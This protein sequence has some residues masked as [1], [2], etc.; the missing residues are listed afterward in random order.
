MAAVNKIDS[1]V[2]ALR[3]AE[4]ATF[5]ANP[6]AVNWYDLEPNSYGDFGGNSTL[7]ARNPI[8]AG[9]Q[10]KKGVITDKDASGALQQDVT[11]T[12]FERLLQG[13]F[14]AD[15]REKP[16][17]TSFGSAKIVIDDVTTLADTYTASGG[18]YT[19]GG[20]G[21]LA[22]DIV[23]GTGFTESANNGLHVVATVGA[24][25][26]T[27]DENLVDETPP[28]AARLTMVGHEF[29]AGDLSVVVSG[30][31]PT[32]VSAGGKDLT[33][34]GLIPGEFIYV[35]GDGATK[36]FFNAVN[37]GFARVK[38]VTA[39]VI[40]LDKTESTMVADDGTIDGAGGAGQ[41]IRIFCG[42]VLK[43]ETGSL[44][45]RRTYHLE[46]E[47]GAPDDEEPA[48]IQAEYLE[49]A[50]PNEITFNFSTADKLTADLTF[51]AGDSA[52]VAGDVALRSAAGTVVTVTESDAFNTSS[53]VVRVNMHVISST[54]AAPTPLLGFFEEFTIAISNGVTPNKA[55]G[56]I[57]A[58]DVSTG[59]FTVNGSA[60][61]YFADVASKAAVE[62]NSDVTMDVQVVKDN[63]GITL[64]IPLIA[65]G[66]GLLSIES[67]QPIKVPL[68]HEAASG[69][70]VDA[71]MDHTLL[72][73][74]WDYLPDAAE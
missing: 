20:G 72:M 21:F 49:G 6:G 74:H 26:I 25:A 39:T 70:A 63:A 52:T 41:L 31:L 32:I 2:T 55:I 54:D 65:L 61:G 11:Q 35:G 67:D 29:T 69:A 71:N 13:F 59:N 73:V 18:D 46:R 16:D 27:V 9:R 56:T 40:T 19:A 8:N 17:T 48:E 62:G 36:K 57:G 4:E 12:N 22:N 58:F 64:D 42:R 10:N 23:L 51:V 5:K 45:T 68:N 30:D 60:T 24:T 44:I 38:S 43:N 33:E 50:V 53:N 47:L 7:L 37:N 1:N 14:F 28:A 3:F 34:L 15:V 66:G